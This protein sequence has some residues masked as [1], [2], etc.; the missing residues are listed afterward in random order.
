MPIKHKNKGET[1]P[2]Q[3]NI[4]RGKKNTDE[5]TPKANDL[6]CLGKYSEIKLREDK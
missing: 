2:N 6:L 3:L 4:V 1:I 5:W